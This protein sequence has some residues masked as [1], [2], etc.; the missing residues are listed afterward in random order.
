MAFRE[1]VTAVIEAPL[2][3]PCAAAVLRTD[4]EGTKKRAGRPVRKPPGHDERWRRSGRGGDAGAVWP[5]PG[6]AAQA[7]S[8]TGHGM[9][10]RTENG[11]ETLGRNEERKRGFTQRR[12]R[13]HRYGWGHVKIR[14][15]SLDIQVVT[16]AKDLGRRA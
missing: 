11:H 3:K 4:S 1:S 13:N 5:G 16:G 12:N 7:G 15:V 6:R 9:R 14:D 2:E 8:R 10:E